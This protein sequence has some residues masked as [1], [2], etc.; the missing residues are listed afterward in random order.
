MEGGGF[1]S[2]SCLVWSLSRLLLAFWF[3]LLAKTVE[4][5]EGEGKGVPF[6]DVSMGLGWVGPGL[7]LW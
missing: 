6:G 5:S 1:V 3:S 7:G 4:R 2:F